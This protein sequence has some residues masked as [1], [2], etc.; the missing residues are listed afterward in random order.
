MYFLAKVLQ[1]GRVIARD[2]NGF[3]TERLDAHQ[4]WTPKLHDYMQN[5]TYKEAVVSG[6]RWSVC[7][8][9]DDHVI[10]AVVQTAI[11]ADA[12]II[13]IPWARTKV[14]TTANRNTATNFLANTDIAVTVL[15]GDTTEVLVNRVVTAALGHTG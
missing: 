13:P 9:P 7:D 6:K 15:N 1:R 12:D 11:D 5:F 8:V 14:L 2:A 4:V 3:V 10:P